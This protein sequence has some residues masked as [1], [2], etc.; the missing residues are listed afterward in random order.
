MSLTL[1]RAERLT[2]RPRIFWHI[3]ELMGEVQRRH[4]ICQ[5]YDK[6]M[7]KVNSAY[8]THGVSGTGSLIFPDGILA[9][10]R[11]GNATLTT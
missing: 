2:L 7:N 5:N 10:F 1:L 9:K 6:K 3:L 8:W 4:E 11:A